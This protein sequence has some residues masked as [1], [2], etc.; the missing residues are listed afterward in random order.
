MLP[1]RPAIGVVFLLPD[2]DPLLQCVNQPA[3]GIK[4][5]RAMRGAD[6]DSNADFTRIKVPGAMHDRHMTHGVL[7][8]Y[9]S[10]QTSQGFQRHR[11][12][13]FVFQKRRPLVTRQIAHSAQEQ[14]D[15]TAG[16]VP[17]G[18]RQLVEVDGF[19]REFNH[20]VTRVDKALTD[21]K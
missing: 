10:F 1:F 8:S 12:K 18:F 2:R 3:A 11:R 19:V 20:R 9:L 5:L 16:R 7:V 14:N 15:G 21:T 17:D 13:R 6:G 4:G